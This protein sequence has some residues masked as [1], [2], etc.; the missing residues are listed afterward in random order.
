MDMILKPISYLEA[1][2]QLMRCDSYTRLPALLDMCPLLDAEDFLRLLGEEWSGFDNIGLHIDELMDTPF[3]AWGDEEPILEMMR[4]E[5]LEAYNALPEVVTIYRGCY[6]IN[7]FGFSWSLSKEAAEK[8]PTY[9]RYWRPNEQALL[10]TA[11]VLKKDIVAVKLD[12]GESEI[13]TWNAKRISTRRIKTQ[14]VP[15][16]FASAIVAPASA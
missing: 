13:I 10:I 6:Q 12:R 11:K 3:A 14:E 7:T 8:F 16:F 4:P 1:Q 15:S 5:E 9:Y 2:K